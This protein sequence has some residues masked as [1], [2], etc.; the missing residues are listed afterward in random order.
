[1]AEI[2]SPSNEGPLT[3]IEAYRKG[4]LGPFLTAKRLRDLNHAP[5]AL[6]AEGSQAALFAAWLL[7]DIADYRHALQRW[8]ACVEVGGVLVVTVPHASCMIVAR[9][10]HR[11]CGR[12]RSGFIPPP[13]FLPKS[14]RH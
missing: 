4:P 8:F 10:C 6:P 3:S 14:R 7:Q 9:N 1:M 13:R 2:L 11:C 12:G 5:D